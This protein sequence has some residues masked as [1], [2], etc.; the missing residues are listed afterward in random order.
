MG[1]PSSVSSVS[2]VNGQQRQAMY[3]PGQPG[4]YA[5]GQQGHV[6]GRH[7]RQKWKALKSPRLQQNQNMNRN[8]QNQNQIRQGHGHGHGHSQGQVLQNG[9]GL[10]G[11][12]THL[13]SSV[14]RSPNH[15]KGN[16][17]GNVNVN[18]GEASLSQLWLMKN[19]TNLN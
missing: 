14:L 5:Q 3:T 10:N 17:N 2:P 7:C 1:Y 12:A 8:R 6:N 15:C 18:G 9:Y 4:Y 16:G 19:M 13:L 11:Q